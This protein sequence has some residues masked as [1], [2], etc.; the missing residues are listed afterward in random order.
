MIVNKI[1]LMMGLI[2]IKYKNATLSVLTLICIFLFV[3]QNSISV[4]DLV[5]GK[6]A[7]ELI[8]LFVFFFLLTIT[9]NASFG[10]ALV[11]VSLPL[12]FSPVGEF[13][14]LYPVKN[15]AFYF[16]STTVLFV[17]VRSGKAWIR[18]TRKTDSFFMGLGAILLTSFISI[19]NPPVVN[20]S[21]FTIFQVPVIPGTYS[22]SLL[23]F[24]MFAVCICF[25]T[26]VFSY[27]SSRR[28]QIF[29]LDAT[30]FGWAIAVFFGV[31]GMIKILTGY[32]SA[33]IS[34]LNSYRPTSSFYSVTSAGGYL[35][36][37][38]PLAIFRCRLLFKKKLFGLATLLAFLCIF[39]IL[40]VVGTTSR[41]AVLIVFIATI[42]ILLFFYK[43]LFLRCFAILLITVCII[44]V[45]DWTYPPKQYTQ[46]HTLDSNKLVDKPGN[47]SYLL[48]RIPDN[49]QSRI[50]LNVNAL[51]LWT[52]FPI[53]G[54]GFGMMPNHSID[55]V[56]VS[57]S[58]NFIT[59]TLA[60]QGL[61]GLIPYALIFT[62]FMSSIFREKILL[63][64]GL[65]F[66]SYSTL[67]LIGIVIHSLLHLSFYSLWT[68]VVIAI[69]ALGV[70]E[71]RPLPK[72]T[73][74]HV[75]SS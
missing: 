46:I 61:F 58:H 57:D 20:G 6:K 5:T 23:Q 69:A 68:W 67:M 55:G 50:D 22:F 45:M 13:S 33:E 12:H 43:D 53:T 10:I 24:L 52:Q 2:S 17:L 14:Q 31:L 66:F 25:L 62:L 42:W 75:Q 3:L 60:E 36:I 37:F 30:L 18:F 32:D 28:R 74:A 44:S 8:A 7:A 64:N 70:F 73:P 49:H 9:I 21:G 51:L 39:C 40:V 38:L 35:A 26:L 16:A 72:K 1:N 15:I 27:G 41:S 11:L 48:Q 54:V 63:S 71:I 34:Y 19:L 47:Q 4:G 59:T 29:I 65:H 56:K